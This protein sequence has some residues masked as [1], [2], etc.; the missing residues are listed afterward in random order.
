MRVPLVLVIGSALAVALAMVAVVRGPA[1]ASSPRRSVVELIEFLPRPPA[2]D[3]TV[4]YTAQVQAAIDAAAGRTLQLP[5]FPVLVSPPQGANRCLVVG[6]PIAIVGGPRSVLREATGAVQLLRCDTVDGVE[7]DGFTLS[8]VGGVGHAL[9]HGTLQLWRCRNVVLR[10]VTVLDSDADGIAIADSEDVRVESCVVRRAS[11]AGIYLSNCVDSVVEGN[12]VRDIAG[13]LTANGDRVG[14]GILLLS[15]TNVVCAGNV[16]AG[17]V[18]NGILCGSNTGQARPRGTLIANNRIE[19]F[20]N[21]SNAQVASGVQLANLDADHATNTIVE[22]NSIRACGPYGIA[23]D[24][25]DGAVLS[26]NTLLECELGGI[27]IGHARDVVVQ[28][29]TVI[30]PDTAGFG[31][32]AAI[33]LHATAGNVRVRGNTLVRSPSYAG[34]V[35]VLPVIDAA[36]PGANQVD[37]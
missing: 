13:H 26:G 17:G 34:S 19:G 18:G 35:V 33:Y 5:P 10:D 29:N 30:N 25:H 16:L 36:P 1:P 21:P 14:T 8:G 6:A 4:D 3:G 27:S 31:G 32:Q 11:K 9:G 22:G 2:T 28:D 20:A 15:N 7:L 23:L 12:V 24:D 37:P